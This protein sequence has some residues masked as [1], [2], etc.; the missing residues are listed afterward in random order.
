V[1]ND[2][3]KLTVSAR[4][5]DRKRAEAVLGRFLK[6]TEQVHH[7]TLTQIV[8]CQDA[9]YHQLLHNR[10][11]IK[12]LGGDPNRDK[13][14]PFCRSPRRS[15]SFQVGRYCWYCTAGWKLYAAIGNVNFR[16]YGFFGGFRG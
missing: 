4:R 16:L 9:S 12:R 11:R 3:Y 15:D 10:E 6:R 1:A 8:I 14:C 5:R 13:I 2:R 7:H